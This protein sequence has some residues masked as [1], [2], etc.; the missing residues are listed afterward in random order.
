LSS[1]CFFNANPNTPVWNNLQPSALTDKSTTTERGDDV[2]EVGR[3]QGTREYERR[4]T[5][6]RSRVRNGSK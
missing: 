5:K 1:L 6:R 4:R 2:N 3:N